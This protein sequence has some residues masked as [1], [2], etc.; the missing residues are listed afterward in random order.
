MRK[1]RSTNK[2]F[3]HFVLYLDN[4]NRKYYF[5]AQGIADDLNI[6]RSSV[7]RAL[8][9]DNKLFEHG[10]VRRD[11]LHRSVVEHLVKREL[12]GRS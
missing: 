8:K 7:Y 10:V 4:G 12:E 11:Y 3:Y 9:T 2:T 1:A 6:S 5:T